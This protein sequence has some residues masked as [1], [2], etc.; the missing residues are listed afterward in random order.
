MSQ[1]LELSG[2]KDSFSIV[3]AL[4]DVIIR[5]NGYHHI[6]EQNE[7]T[8]TYYKGK[9]IEENMVW[10]SSL[11]FCIFCVGKGEIDSEYGKPLMRARVGCMVLECAGHIWLLYMCTTA[12]SQIDGTIENNIH[13]QYL[14]P[15]LPKILMLY[16]KNISL[17]LAVIAKK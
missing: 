9:S 6:I 17:Y 10:V 13:F 3:G 4:N 12:S 5:I 16:A 7:L 8:E 1:L 15:L 14:I 11:S 2:L